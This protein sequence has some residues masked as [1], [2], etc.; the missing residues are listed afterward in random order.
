[1]FRNN[2][3]SVDVYLEY[4]FKDE[5]NKYYDAV[6][7]D[8]G[9]PYKFKFITNMQESN[10]GRIIKSKISGLLKHTLEKWFKP[11]KGEYFLLKDQLEVW[12][13][14]GLKESLSQGDK[15]SVKRVVLNNNNVIKNQT[16]Y[17]I[18]DN[19][20]YKLRGNDFWYFNWWFEPIQKP[21]LKI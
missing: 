2:N 12:N 9:S 3:G 7:K 16:I 20:E 14:L 8:W 19:K 15:I 5:P 1:M 18:K 21:N 13:S 4:S 10:E 11:I 6:F 17:L